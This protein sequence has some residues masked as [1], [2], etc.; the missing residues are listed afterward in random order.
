MYYATVFLIGNILYMVSEPIYKG[1]KG[2]LSGAGVIKNGM[3]PVARHSF[4]PSK[5]GIPQRIKAKDKQ[6]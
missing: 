2:C 4:V 3:I 1:Q 5:G 6:L